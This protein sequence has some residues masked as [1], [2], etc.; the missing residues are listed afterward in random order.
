LEGK[1]LGCNYGGLAFLEKLFFYT[2]KPKKL[3]DI[4]IEITN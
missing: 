1:K 2:M 4:K 3:L